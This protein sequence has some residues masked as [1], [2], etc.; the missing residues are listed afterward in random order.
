MC[1]RLSSLDYRG[2][3]FHAVYASFPSD[4]YSQCTHTYSW[5]C[6]DWREICTPVFFHVNA[7]LTWRQKIARDAV[8]IFINNICG[9]YWRGENVTRIPDKIWVKIHCLISPQVLYVFLNIP[10]WKK[11]LANRPIVIQKHKLQFFYNLF[12]TL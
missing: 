12:F 6:S 7:S 1:Y 5:H 11:K 4:S 10:K 9:V 3:F 8:S 2:S